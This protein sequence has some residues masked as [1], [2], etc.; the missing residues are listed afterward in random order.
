MK[1]AITGAD[2]KVGQALVGQFDHE[3]FH[4]TSL[5]LP[6]HD[7]SNLVGL[8]QTPS[9]N[10]MVSAILFLCKQ[11]QNKHGSHRPDVRAILN[12]HPG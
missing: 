8:T 12:K 4:V 9:L 3:Q 1:I 6:D 5:D 7:V 10:S 11:E 2:G